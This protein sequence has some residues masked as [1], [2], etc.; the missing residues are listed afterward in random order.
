MA[1]E[2]DN[3]AEIAEQRHFN[4]RLRQ[5]HYQQRGETWPYLTQIVA[6]ERAEGGG[7]ENPLVHPEKY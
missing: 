2:V 7:G 4:Q 5:A 6:I 3:A 1:D